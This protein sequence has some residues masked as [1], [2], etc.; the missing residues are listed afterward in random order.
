[1]R[2]EIEGAQRQIVKKVDDG[3]G[4]FVFFPHGCVVEV[5]SVADEIIGRSQVEYLIVEVDQEP[6]A[7]LRITPHIA[8]VVSIELDKMYKIGVAGNTV[9]Q[10]H[11]CRQLFQINQFQWSFGRYEELEHCQVFIFFVEYRVIGRKLKIENQLEKIIDRLRQ[12]IQRVRAYL[13]IV[14]HPSEEPKQPYKRRSKTTSE[15]TGYAG[16]FMCQE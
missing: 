8:V 5:Q 2:V 15:T 10:I 16:L 3:R 7:L 9:D 1:L 12:P 11:I 6:F 4:L 13:A 14:D